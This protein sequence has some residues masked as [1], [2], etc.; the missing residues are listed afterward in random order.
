MLFGGNFEPAYIMTITVLQCHMQ[1]SLNKRNA[2]LIQKHMDDSLQVPPNRG[3]LRF[4]G[5]PEENLAFGGRTVAGEIADA[6]SGF[7]GHRHNNSTAA[8]GGGGVDMSILRSKGKLNAKASVLSLFRRS[9]SVH[10]P[11][12]RKKYT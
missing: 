12:R 3:S 1:M 6:G 4:I 7:S 2:A 10:H 11:L 5:I 8:G 9:R